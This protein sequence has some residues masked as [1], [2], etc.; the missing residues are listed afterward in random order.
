VI[1]LVSANNPG[2]L[3]KISKKFGDA[4]MNI[5]YTH[6][7]GFSGSKAA[8]FIFKVSGLKKAQELFAGGK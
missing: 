3:D 4:G 2:V 1:G 5:S 6:V 7:S 8:P